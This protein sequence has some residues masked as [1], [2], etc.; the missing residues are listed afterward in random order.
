MLPSHPIARIKKLAVLLAVWSVLVPVF[1]ASTQAQEPTPQRVARPFPP[2][3]YIPDH[4]FDTRHIALNLRFDW[5]RE[6]VIGSETI[7]LA[8]LVSNLPE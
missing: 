8:P 3:Q 7:V 6:Q 4:N 5:E 1:I 2:A